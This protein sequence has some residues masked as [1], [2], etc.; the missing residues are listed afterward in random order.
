MQ[1]LEFDCIESTQIFLNE[2]IRKGELKPPIMVIAKRQSGGI[3]SRGNLWENVKEGLYFSF[4]LPMETLPLDLPLESISI[5]MGFVFKEVLQEKGSQVWLKWPNDLYIDKQKVGGVLCSKL[6]D[7]MIC[8]IGLNLEVASQEFGGLDI[9]ISKERVLESFIE[10][11]END[12]KKSSW[13]QIFSKYSL[14]FTNNFNHTFHYNGKLIPLCNA[15]LCE[16]GAILI[17]GEKIYSLR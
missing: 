13:K 7:I 12:K 11:L 17:E 6:R 4:A 9:K 1:I 5:Y 15:L 2:G 14:E 8:G 3:G 10:R 16:D